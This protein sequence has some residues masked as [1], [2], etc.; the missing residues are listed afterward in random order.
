MYAIVKVRG[1]Q[2][3]A[4]PNS[5]IRVPLL[6]NEIGQGVTFDQVLLWS[7]GQTTTVGS[8]LVA[9]KSVSGEVVRHSRSDKIRIF[10]KKRRK[11]YRRRGNHRQWFTEVRL[12]GFGSQG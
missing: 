2:F 7:D 6:D 3:K 10:K 5:I 9:G 11:K 4:E 12:T 8:P 1:L